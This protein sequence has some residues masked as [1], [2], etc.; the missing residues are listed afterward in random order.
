[1]W[2]WIA[3]GVVVLVVVLGVL[4]IRE[5]SLTLPGVEGPFGIFPDVPGETR[6][7]AELT[8]AAGSAD[9][10]VRQEA[11]IFLQRL[12]RH[13]K[14]DA[15]EAEPLFLA[16]VR[17]ADRDVRSVA[18]DGLSFPPFDPETSG[19]VLVSLVDD[20]DWKVRA[21]A[22]SGLEALLERHAAVEGT[23][24]KITFSTDRRMSVANLDAAESALV[25]AWN[26]SSSDVRRYASKALRY[27]PKVRYSVPKEWLEFSE[28]EARE[29]A[30][31]MGLLANGETLLDAVW[32]DD[33]AG[34]FMLLKA[35]V[36]PNS[37]SEMPAGHSAL[38]II[39]PRT[40]PEITRFLLDA[41]ADV[42][43]KD[44]SGKVPWD[45][46]QDHWDER[47]VPFG[48]ESIEMLRAAGA[49]PEGQS[50]PKR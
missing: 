9:P 28:D 19:P 29:R 3:A 26:D 35:G 42:T 49:A 4:M 38:F 15:A 48:K 41:G 47:W 13:D 31:A 46:V 2:K 16:G 17:D 39:G 40:R 30:V 12:V 5:R 18:T 33:V 24:R 43:R 34:V 1:M 45:W 22:V 36:D 20:G 50:E 7:M 25:R 21:N 44:K 32:K 37:G 27:R 14:I 11:L 6:S 10:E 8:E 23:V